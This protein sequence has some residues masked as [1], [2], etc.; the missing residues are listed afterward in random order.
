MDGSFGM[1]FFADP[2]GFMSPYPGG[3]ESNDGQ[4]SQESNDPFAYQNYFTQQMAQQMMMQQAQYYKDQKPAHEENKI[5][6]SRSNN[7]PVRITEEKPKNHTKNHKSGND[8]PKSTPTKITDLNIWHLAKQLFR[9]IPSS[10]KIDRIFQGRR[11]PAPIDYMDKTTWRELLCEVVKDAQR[12]N[13]ELSKFIKAPPMIFA[14]TATEETTKNQTNL[15]KFPTENISSSNLLLHR[16]VSCIVPVDT[17]ALKTTVDNDETK[18]FLP[19]CYS[20]L[21]QLPDDKY[22]S[23]D[24]ETRL[25]CE[26]DSLELQHYV[27]EEVKIRNTFQQEIDSYYKELRAVQSEIDSQRSHIIRSLP[28]FR[29]EQKAHQAKIDAF[30]SHQTAQANENYIS[31]RRKRKN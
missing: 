8:V 9:T 23:L 4:Q 14:E 10:E 22:L 18:N 30:K 11:P 2:N 1:G 7:T 25:R 19:I 27:V 21:P 26:L 17:S 15:F 5:K 13:P 29:R 24:F 16:L 28:A 3:T 31:P 12:M 6:N 20:L